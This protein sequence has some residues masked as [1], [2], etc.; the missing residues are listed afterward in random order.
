[1]NKETTNKSYDVIIIGA[2]LSGLSSGYFIKKKYPSL[3]LLIIEAKDRIGNYLFLSL[4]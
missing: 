3:S 4:F 2:G 1:M